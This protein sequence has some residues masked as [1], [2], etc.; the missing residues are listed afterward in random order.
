MQWKERVKRKVELYSEASRLGRYVAT[1]LADEKKA[2]IRLAEMQSEV[3][4][5]YDN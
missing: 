4:R 1:G 3:E 2:E 5:M